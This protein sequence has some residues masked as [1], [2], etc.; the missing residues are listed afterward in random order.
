[1]KFILLLVI[2]IGVLA[3]VLSRRGATFGKGGDNTYEGRSAEEHRIGGTG[4]GN[5]AQGM[6][7]GA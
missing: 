1:M 4:A 7:P 2:V 3:F 6:G 5:S